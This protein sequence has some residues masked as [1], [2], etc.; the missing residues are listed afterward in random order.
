VSL[1]PFNEKS[2]FSVGVTWRDGLHEGITEL[3]PFSY[4]GIIQIRFQGVLSVLLNGQDTPN[5]ITK[6]TFVADKKQVDADI[7]NEPG[8][9]QIIEGAGIIN[10]KR[11]MNAMHPVNEQCF[12]YFAEIV[13]T[14]KATTHHERVLSL[15]VDRI[16]RTFNCQTCAIALI[17]P[18]SEYLRIDQCYN[19]SLTFCNSFRRRIATSSIGQLLWT[20]KPIVIPDSTRDPALADEIALE[21]PFGSCICLQIAVDQQTLGYLHVDCAEPGALGLADVELL[22]LFADIAGIAVIK[23]SLHD[24]NIRLDRVDRETGLEKYPPFLEKL[25]AAMERAEEFSENFAVLIL[26]VD[27]FKDTV[28]TYGYDVSHQLLKEL[29]GSVQLLLRPVDAAARYGFDE[30]ILLL[31]NTGLEG[32]QDFAEHLRLRIAE[33]E[34]TLRKIHT[35]VS[36]GLAA[37][38]RNGNT[39]DTVLTTAKK[40]LFEAQRRG[41]NQAFSYESE[42]YTRP[43]SLPDTAQS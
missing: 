29:G 35:S 10:H 6:H 30:F 32:G 16:V 31:A 13:R 8:T 18:K 43:V 26:D 27:N 28:N 7:D 11:R 3:L 38:P 12:R 20:G 34:W 4:A 17:D 21:H 33:Q 39:I 36:I 37:F 42:W 41:R 24:E 5:G 2:R 15:I 40:A 14:L 25:R 1:P 22:H 23:S 9:L 19:L